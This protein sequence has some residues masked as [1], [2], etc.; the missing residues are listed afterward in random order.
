MQD[1]ADSIG[2]TTRVFEQ[3]L[4]KCNSNVKWMNTNLDKIERWL[5]EQQI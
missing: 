3:S 5:N 4:E 1:N 2:R